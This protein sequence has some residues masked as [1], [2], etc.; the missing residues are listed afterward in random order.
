MLLKENCCP[1]PRYLGKLLGRE[2]GPAT[3]L[4]ILNSYRDDAAYYL[5]ILVVEE[6]EN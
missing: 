5:I 3:L 4:L 6:T 1:G 2:P